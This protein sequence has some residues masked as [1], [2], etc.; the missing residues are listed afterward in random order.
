MQPKSTTESHGLRRPA[1]GEGERAVLEWLQEAQRRLERDLPQ[2]GDLSLSPADIEALLELAR[3]AAH[4][5][6][7]RTNAPLVA[8]LVGVVTARCTDTSLRD[9][10]AVALGHEK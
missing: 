4:E 2:C 1:V 8:Y 7:E 10:I 6:G 5:S 9:V 3:E